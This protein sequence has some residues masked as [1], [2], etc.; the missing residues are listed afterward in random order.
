MTADEWST[1]QC[2]YDIYDHEFGFGLD[3]CARAENAKHSCYYTKETDG[4]KHDWFE[5]NWCNPP[6]SNQLPWLIKAGQEMQIGHTSVL[7]LKYDPSTMHGR[8]ASEFADELRIITHRLTFEGARNCATF[9]S[10]F[11]I[12]RPRLHTRKTDARILYVNYKEVFNVDS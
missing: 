2:L 4:L 3:V 12:F 7:L 8:L 9:P 5:S 11:A 10:A 6:Y 1:P